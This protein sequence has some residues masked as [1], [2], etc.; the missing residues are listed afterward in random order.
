M[1][2]RNA[3]EGDLPAI[4]DIFNYEIVH[5]AYV[6]I[7]A[8]WT[9]D[10][11]SKW[12]HKKQENNFPIL[13]A[14]INEEVIGYATYGKFREREAYNTTVEY[15]IYIH[16]DHRRKGIAYTLVTQLIQLAKEQG[17]HTMVGGLDAGNAPSIAFHKRLGFKEVAHF[18]AVARKF[19][20]WLDLKFFQLMLG[21]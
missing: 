18:K 17:Y 9:L 2:I 8:P 4:L 5:T 12:Y 7:Y 1:T 19:D 20:R 16:R 21:D 10:D 6:Y 15:S 13:V 3:K 14:E 11:M